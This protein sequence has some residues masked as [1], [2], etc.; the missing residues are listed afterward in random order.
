MQTFS[1]K[2]NFSALREHV[3]AKMHEFIKKYAKL[4]I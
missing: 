1:K 4:I 3:Q 2:N